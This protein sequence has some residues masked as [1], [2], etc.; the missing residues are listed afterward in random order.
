MPL[1][2]GIPSDSSSTAPSPSTKDSNLIEPGNLPPFSLSRSSPFRSLHFPQRL[3]QH[4]IS[5]RLALRSVLF[6]QPLTIAHPMGSVP[7]LLKCKSS[8]PSYPTTPRYA[9]PLCP[10]PKLTSLSACP[11]SPSATRCHLAETVAFQPCMRAGSLR[12]AREDVDV[13]RVLRTHCY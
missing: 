3:T 5:L 9:M 12:R 6:G 4:C 10:S 11:R 8:S 7:A 2:R 1:H 13:H